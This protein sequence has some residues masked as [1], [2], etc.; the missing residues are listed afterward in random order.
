M[1][2]T[3]RK[4]HDDK[5]EDNVYIDENI[6]DNEMMLTLPSVAKNGIVP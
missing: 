6:A 2:A 3:H 1:E 4:Q 5:H